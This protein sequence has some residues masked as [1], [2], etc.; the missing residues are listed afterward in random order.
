MQSKKN[1]KINGKKKT[2]KK[3]AGLISMGSSFVNDVLPTIPHS[4]RCPVCDEKHYKDDLIYDVSS[5]RDDFRMNNP[6][7]I[8]VRSYKLGSRRRHFVMETFTPTVFYFCCMN[9]SLHFT[10]RNQMSENIIRGRK[11]NY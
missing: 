4:F 8:R 7:G 9:C 2:K 6:E 11:R 10:F 5:F 1:K 3:G